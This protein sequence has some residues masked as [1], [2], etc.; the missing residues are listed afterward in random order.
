[1]VQE[2]GDFLLAKT[3]WVLSGAQS[4]SSPATGLSS[5]TLSIAKWDTSLGNPLV[6]N[7]SGTDM[8]L[9]RGANP[10][11]VLNN[12]NVQ[13]SSLNFTHNTAS[14]DGVSPESLAASFTVSSK[15]A[16]GQIYSQD[17]S[18]LT[19]LRK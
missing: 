8:T 3:G 15:T 7:L 17:F 16:T 6:I 11:V 18:T 19:Y 4:V 14:G 9:S 1:M 13:I 12:S 2:E 5:A 10:A